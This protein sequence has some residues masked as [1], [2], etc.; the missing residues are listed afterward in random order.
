MSA[1]IVLKMTPENEN[2]PACQS[3]GMQPPAT[4]PMVAPIQMAFL[5]MGIH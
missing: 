4:E 2:I 1:P 3:E 5:L